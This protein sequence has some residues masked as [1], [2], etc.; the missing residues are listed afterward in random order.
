MRAWVVTTVMVAS[1]L[2]GVDLYLLAARTDAMAPVGLS[3]LLFALLFQAA[4]VIGIALAVGA[5]HY[6]NCERWNLNRGVICLD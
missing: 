5:L 2:I 6:S 3:R 4:G 1:M